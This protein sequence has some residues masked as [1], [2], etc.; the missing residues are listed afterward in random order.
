M[1]DKYSKIDKRKHLYMCLAVVLAVSTM[2]ICHSCTPPDVVYA[3]ESDKSDPME[4]IVIKGPL[5]SDMKDIAKPDLTLEQGDITYHLVS[6]ELAEVS[7]DGMMTYVSACVP[8]ELEWKQNPPETTVVTLYDQRTESEYKRELSF[9]DMKEIESL[10]E[11]KFSFPITISDYDAETFQLGTI[12][13]SKDEELIHYADHILENMGLSKEYYHINTIEWTGEPYERE[14]K[15]FRDALADGEKKI[16]YVDVTY[17]GEIKTPNTTGYQ[18]ISTYE[19]SKKI[20]D[21]SEST[22]ISDAETNVEEIS[23]P[24]KN[25]RLLEQIRRFLREHMM[26]VTISSLF[27]LFVIGTIYLWHTSKDR[28]KKQKSKELT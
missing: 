25:E 5:F 6:T 17:G 20:E 21:I 14:G 28:T 15:I 11:K 12:L 18:Y 24:E 7:V 8:Y 10:W 13:I 1:K 22:S 4:Q 26:I 9:L 19:M 3:A 16:R 27:L 23:I 2:M